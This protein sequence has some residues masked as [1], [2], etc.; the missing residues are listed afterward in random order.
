MINSFHTAGFKQDLSTGFWNLDATKELCSQCVDATGRT[1]RKIRMNPI[2][3]AGAAGKP[4]F[5][6]VFLWEGFLRGTLLCRSPLAA[7]AVDILCADVA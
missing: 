2:C 1:T 6:G 7:F 5:R 3:F 4:R